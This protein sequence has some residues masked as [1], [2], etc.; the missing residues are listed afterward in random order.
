MASLNEIFIESN[1]EPENIAPRDDRVTTEIGGVEVVPVSLRYQGSDAVIL[2]VLYNIEK[3]IREFDITVATVEWNS[4]GLSLNAQANA[5][6]LADMM[7][8]EGETTVRARG[9]SKP[10]TSTGVRSLTNASGAAQD[11]TSGQK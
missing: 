6:Y 8:L 9:N 1:W 4:A 11:L 10:S 2:S 7:M 3:S 5:Y